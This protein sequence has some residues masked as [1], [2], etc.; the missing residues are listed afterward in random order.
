MIVAKDC[1][2]LFELDGLSFFTSSLWSE[3]Y[4]NVEGIALLSN[5]T[6]RGYIPLPMADKAEREGVLLYSNKDLYEK[7]K[8]DIESAYESVADTFEPRLSLP[9]LDAHNAKSCIERAVAML[10][11]YQKTEFFY[12]DGAFGL[13][14]TNDEARENLLSFGD[15]KL[16]S[17]EYLNRIYFGERSY[18]SRFI[19][20]VSADLDIPAGE[21]WAYSVSEMPGLYGE[22]TRLSQRAVADRK[23]S[24]FS[25]YEQGMLKHL[26]SDEAQNAISSFLEPLN[27]GS[28][29]H[30][31][32][33]YK[34]KVRGKARVF[35]YSIHE[36]D[37]AHL[38]VEAMRE[39]E[40]LIA[41]TTSP[42]IILACKKAAAIVTNQGGMLSHA[43]IVS[44]ELGIPCIVG[45]DN[46]TETIKTGDLVEV[47]ADRGV[48]RILERSS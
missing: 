17:R 33:A 8:I 32:I 22:G 15:F 11:L 38:L 40:I 1:L 48:V 9:H 16:R 37:T 31:H 4:E 46:A 34:G 42:E 29:V 35:K 24:F 25:W 26:F 44:R 41:E 18:V 47:D 23:K 13:Q 45:T 7:L 20:K 10:R 12:T 28:D 3:V 43:A 39:G 21:L 6:W 14:E 5:G 19:R 27:V 2:R 30:G 36:F